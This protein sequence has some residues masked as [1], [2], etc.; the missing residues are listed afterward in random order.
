VV[1]ENP[2]ITSIC[3]AMPNMTI[4]QANVTAALNKKNLSGDDKKR[5]EQYA[6]QTAP[7]YSKAEKYCPQG[8]QIGRV[9]KETHAD[10]T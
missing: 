5:L 1:W 9:L 4:L 2:N 8:I 3:S 6:Q 7:G 10:L